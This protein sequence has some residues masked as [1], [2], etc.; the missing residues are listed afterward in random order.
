MAEKVYVCECGA[1]FQATPGNHAP[2]VRRFRI[3]GTP[4]CAGKVTACYVCANC[5][6]WARPSRT[7]E[8]IVWDCLN[9]CAARG[10]APS[11]RQP[12]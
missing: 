3:R 10:F 8:A 4:V 6:Q 9:G 7:A 12:L 1:L 2:K 11:H 5:Q